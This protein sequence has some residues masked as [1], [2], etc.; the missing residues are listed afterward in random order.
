MNETLIC[1][2]LDQMLNGSITH[3]RKLILVM[4]LAILSRLTY[5][6]GASVEV[7]LVLI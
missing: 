5:N 4:L 6:E 2:P 3:Y 7:K 1:K